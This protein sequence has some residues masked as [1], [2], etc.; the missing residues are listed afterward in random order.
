MEQNSKL[1]KIALWV[2]GEIPFDGQ[3]TTA[4]LH[5]VFD[6]AMVLWFR[7]LSPDGR[8]APKLTWSAPEKRNDVK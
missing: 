4:K 1:S 3:H 6:S 2:P 8:A 7:D 5:P